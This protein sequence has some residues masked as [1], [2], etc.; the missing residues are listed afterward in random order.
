MDVCIL[1]T[2][3]GFSAHFKTNFNVHGQEETKINYFHT[4]VHIPNVESA[5]FM[6]LV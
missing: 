3:T 4:E 2:N 1:H 6:P 5:P